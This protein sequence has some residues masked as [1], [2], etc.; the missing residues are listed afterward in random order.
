MARAVQRALTSRQGRTGG[1]ASEA[2]ESAVSEIRTTV[3]VSPREQFRWTRPALESV[4][5][6][7]EVPY[8]LV[9]IDGASPAP[10]QR[11][12]RLRARQRGFTLVRSEHYISPMEARAL[13]LPHV[14]TEYVCF[15]DNDVL[16][17]RGWLDRLVRCADE[18][19]AWAVGPLYC[20]EEP[21]RGLIHMAGGLAHILE[22]NGRRSFFEEHR[23][24]R[25]LVREVQAHLR[26]EPTELV[27]F[28]CKL[29]R[30]EA[31]DKFDLL[32]KR[33]LS[34]GES[35]DLCLQLRE[36]G[37]P[38]YLEPS[39][40][41][42]NQPPPP[43]LRSGLPFYLLR[44]SDAWNR[45]SLRCFRERWSLPADDWW[46]SD[47][48]RWLTGHRELATEWIA[49]KTRRILGWQRGNRAA[50]RLVEALH[51]RAIRQDLQRRPELRDYERTAPRP[52]FPAPKP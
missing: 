34:C 37:Y 45:I 8:K 44:W 9:Y 17:T 51:R 30:T 50:R 36:A 1:A 16:V 38:V 13:A 39:A 11:Y 7:T 52:A 2:L 12:L 27:E 3:V 35:L 26:R 48:Y 28:H 19:E 20:N 42:S 32:D 46:V 24:P 14:D 25:R 41:V 22:E 5:A 43:F 40:I 18:T 23:F 49:E 33:Y 6:H 21:A 47:H 31:F 4:F 15:V 29:L 10:V